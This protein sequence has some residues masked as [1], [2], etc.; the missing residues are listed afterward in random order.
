MVDLS[1]NQETKP[2]FWIIEW[3][4]PNFRSYKNKLELRSKDNCK[5]ISPD[6]NPVEKWSAIIER[7]EIGKYSLNENLWEEIKTLK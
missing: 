2:G 1:F 5:N 3:G 7:D 6:I 4:E